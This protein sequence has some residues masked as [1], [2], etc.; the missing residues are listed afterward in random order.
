M[1]P[2]VRTLTVAGVV[3]LGSLLG[4]GADQ[5]KAQV[6][7]STP[8]FALGVG[9]PVAPVA[10]VYPGVGVGVIGAPVVAAPV[11]GYPVRPYPYGYGYGYGRGYGYYGRPY[12][13]HYGY[14][15]YGYRRW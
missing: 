6:V 4:T 5:A 8:G 9:A 14:R 15:H 11:Y 10:P 2:N 12:Y 3:A 13:G 1:L 7:V